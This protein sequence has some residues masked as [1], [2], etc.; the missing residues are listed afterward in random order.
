MNVITD[1]YG[2]FH[3]DFPFPALTDHQFSQSNGKLST[4]YLYFAL[5]PCYY[6]TLYR[7]IACREMCQTVTLLTCI[8]KKP[9]SNRGRVTDRQDFMS[10]DFTLFPTAD[11]LY[12]LQLYQNCNFIMPCP[13]RDS[14]PLNVSYLA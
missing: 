1:I 5:S 8:Q 4:L 11:D 2:L 7:N 12:Y 3:K 13:K 6:F 10:R 9:S 14:L